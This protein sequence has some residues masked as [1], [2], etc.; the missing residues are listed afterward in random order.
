MSKRS[1]SQ[2]MRL[3]QTQNQSPIN[4]VIQ[5]I[6]NKTFNKNNKDGKQN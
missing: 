6:L 5:L 1:L 3:N 2:N 4:K